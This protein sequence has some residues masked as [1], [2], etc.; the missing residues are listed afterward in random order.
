MHKVGVALTPVDQKQGKVFV[1]GERWDAHSD[2][3]VAT[4]DEVEI[5][6]L[7]GMTLL[8]RKKAR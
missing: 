2:E 4:G 6:R 3:P 5:L 8:V 1:A 7:Q